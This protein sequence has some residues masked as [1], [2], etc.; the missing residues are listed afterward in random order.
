MTLHTLTALTATQVNDGTYKVNFG[1]TATDADSDTLGLVAEYKLSTDATWKV[2]TT[3]MPATVAATPGGAAVAGVWDL[4]KDFDGN[5]QNVTFNFRVTATKKFFAAG[6]LTAV[7]ANNSTGIK[8]GDSFVVGGKTF[9]FTVTGPVTAGRIAVVL[10]SATATAAQV[11][12]AIIAAINGE[13]TCTVAAASG[14][15]NTINLTS[16]VEG[17]AGNVA[18]TQ[19]ISNSAT[20]TPVG[21]T[22]GL[23]SEVVISSTANITNAN[24]GDADTK[25]DDVVTEITTDKHDVEINRLEGTYS[26][27]GLV[28][29]AGFRW[30]RAKSAFEEIRNGKQTIVTIF[31][32]RA[33][34]EGVAVLVSPAVYAK[35]LGSETAT[36][37][38]K[39]VHWLM[40]TAWRS[41]SQ[42][43]SKSVTVYA[44]QSSALADAGNIS[45]LKINKAT[46]G[47]YLLSYA[48]YIRMSN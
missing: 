12:A 37:V 19:S 21:M 44:I 11:K 5:V 25:N 20:L 26:Q 38:E 31:S 13:A 23:A 7:A 2:A 22:G 3:T 1:F 40:N 36:V 8:V 30:S 46:T 16:K 18:I 41:F 4:D 39:P 42:L 27:K 17:T 48:D 33:I 43:F 9:E 10:P 15:A 45:K 34:G 6:T 28:S 24:T 35:L 47:A 14:A 32:D 29:S